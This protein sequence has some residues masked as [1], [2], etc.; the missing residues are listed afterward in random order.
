[1]EI[2]EPTISKI[3][4]SIEQLEK[5]KRF[6]NSDK[7]TPMTKEK[8][9]RELTGICFHCG[10]IPDYIITKHYEGVTLIERYCMIV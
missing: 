7:M 9:Q 5:L 4:I 6:L 2:K 3:E 10:D 1:M 8:K